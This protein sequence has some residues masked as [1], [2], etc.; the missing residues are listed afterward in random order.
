M[1][2][3]LQTSIAGVNVIPTTFLA[4]TLLYWIIAIV[5]AID[6]EGLNFDIDADADGIA[7]E[8]FS[9][10]KLGDIPVT[11]YAS[12]LFL[13]FWTLNMI[14][15]MVTGS[16]GGV[17]NIVALIPCFVISGL[18]TRGITIPLKPLFVGFSGN[19]V[20]REF[21]GEIGELKYS[22]NKDKMS[23]VSIDKGSSLLNCYIEGD[24]EL[25]QGA[26]VIIVEKNEKNSYLIK[27]YQK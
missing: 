24:Y 1:L 12:I 4:L 15:S 26:T 17:P 10:L 6:I 9:W 13:S 22:I 14:V 21:I 27:P 23:Q 3:L 8:L 11:I 5:G 18:I 16:Q 7:S 25:P 19:D 2:E 20:S